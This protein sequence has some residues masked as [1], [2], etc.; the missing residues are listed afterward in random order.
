MSRCFCLLLK[1]C[2]QL[3][4]PPK[5]KLRF[6]VQK[7]AFFGSHG[8]PGFKA[9]TAGK[10]SRA[11]IGIFVEGDVSLTEDLTVAGAIRYEDYD[12]FGNT[13]D[14]ATRTSRIRLQT[15]ILTEKDNGIQMIVNEG[16]SR[17]INDKSSFG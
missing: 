1:L 17:S 2:C 15:R 3:L 7:I 8:F 10:T 9:E 14:S 5:P 13:F 12:T 4:T 6:F 16:T 11:N